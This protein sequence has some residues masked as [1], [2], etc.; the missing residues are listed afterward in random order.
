MYN[1]GVH[2]GKS[3]KGYFYVWVEGTAG[4]GAQEIGSCLKKHIM[5]NCPGVKKLILWS[6][7]C[8][9]QNRNIKVTL[10]L[11][12]IIASHPTLKKISLRFM[13]PGHS[14]LPN[15]SE[16]GDVECHLK[17]NQRVYTDDD[18]INIMKKSRR[19]HPFIVTKMSCE[20]FLSS[21]S[22]ESNITNRKS[23]TEEAKINWFTFREIEV[24]EKEPFS[25]FVK[26]K[27]SDSTWQ[28]INIFKKASRGR[29]CS[30]KNLF[31]ENLNLRWP[32]GKGISQPKMKDL[33]SMLHL[34]PNDAKPFY[35]KFFED[36]SIV[37]D[38]DGFNGEL[39]FEIEFE[40]DS[41]NS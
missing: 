27:L 26:S 22:L 37:D 5:E 30:S 18:Y 17:T 39:D 1:C 24:R 32:N 25:I 4:R 12:H 8:G 33:K 40:G 9:G 41:D 31:S 34:I 14:F 21:E 6:D 7:S 3:N 36:V 15:D 10:M 28:E 38:I 13:I 35:R 23:N 29:P 16:F 20:E 19:K 11:K 2:S